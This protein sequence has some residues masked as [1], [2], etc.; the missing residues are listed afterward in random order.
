MTDGLLLRGP[1]WPSTSPSA[2]RP[3]PG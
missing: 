3:L 2:R 1:R